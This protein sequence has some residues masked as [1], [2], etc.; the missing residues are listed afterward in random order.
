MENEIALQLA[1]ETVDRMCSALDGGGWQYTKGEDLLSIEFEVEGEDLP[2][3]FNVS[4]NPENSV[5]TLRSP[6]PI[7]VPADRR[8]DMAL[9]V[10]K[11]NTR[12]NDGCF[13]YD[14]KNGLLYYCMTCGYTDSIM[15]NGAFLYE[16]FN[17]CAMVEEYNDRLLLVSEGVITP[18]NIIK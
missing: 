6:L 14:M 7:T 8:I 1:R 12:L 2:M 16:I 9:A 18:E 4:A 11:I 13:Q 5:L 10:C 17:S 15:G 3:S